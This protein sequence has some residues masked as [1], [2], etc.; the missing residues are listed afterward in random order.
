[1]VCN[2][3]KAIESCAAGDSWKF[4]ICYYTNFYYPNTVSPPSGGHGGGGDK[5]LGTVF[6]ISSFP[7]TICPGGELV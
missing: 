3:A 1:M 2:Q 4:Y 7:P 5:E 6:I